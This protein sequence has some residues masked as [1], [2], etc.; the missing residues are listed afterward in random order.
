M[1]SA[2]MAA[3]LFRGRWVNTSISFR[4]R[5]AHHLLRLP[6]LRVWSSLWN[7][8]WRRRVC[9][10]H[11]VSI[12]YVSAVC[13]RHRW[14]HLWVW[15]PAPSVCLSTTEEHPG[16]I[17]RELSRYS[18]GVDVKLW[19]INFFDFIYL[20]IHWVVISKDH[21]VF[22]IITSSSGMECCFCLYPSLPGQNG[23]HFADEIFKCIFMN[24]KLRVLIQISIKFVPKGPV[25]ND[26]VL[27]QV[28]AWCRTGDKPLPELWRKLTVMAEQGGPGALET[29]RLSCGG[30]DWKDR[31]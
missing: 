18:E 2:K 4:L 27:M 31:L 3:I 21:M 1:S 10:R 29:G 23:R 6:H 9:L 8:Q 30:R 16:G 24:E 22:H 26:L 28:I 14:Q 7:Q 13:L 15:V 19:K 5:H 17:W 11:G 12:W 20:V 25:D